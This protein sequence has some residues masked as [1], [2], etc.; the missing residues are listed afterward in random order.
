MLSLRQPL[1]SLPPPGSGTVGGDSKLFFYGPGV[2]GVVGLGPFLP[3]SKLMVLAV[4]TP[5][6]PYRES[7]GGLRVLPTHTHTH[8]VI[9]RL[10]TQGCQ[11]CLSLFQDQVG[12][13]SVEVQE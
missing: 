5:E 6:S 10:G 1:M 8:T 11:S 3:L 12:I 2:W 13:L 4:S 7:S 9:C